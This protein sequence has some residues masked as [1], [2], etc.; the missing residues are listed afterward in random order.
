MCVCFEHLLV[1]GIWHPHGDEYYDGCLVIHDAT[2]S[3]GLV[4]TFWRNVLPP[5]SSLEGA[6]LSKHW[7][8]STKLHSVAAQN[9]TILYDK[10]TECPFYHG[11]CTAALWHKN[12]HVLRHPTTADVL[13]QDI[14][15]YHTISI[16]RSSGKHIYSGIILKC[17]PCHWDWTA[18]P[19]LNSY[20]SMHCTTD[21]L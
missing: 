15:S 13:L 7:Q 3:G 21:L 1:Y 12:L 6:D 8:T 11:L 17:L 14:N 20:A 2:K 4:W 5:P 16:N 19:L 10:Y 18:F 9:N